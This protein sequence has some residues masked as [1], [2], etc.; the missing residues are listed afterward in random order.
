[1]SL[2]VCFP[3]PPAPNVCYDKKERPSVVTI[4]PPEEADAHGPTDALLAEKLCPHT[5][6]QTPG[7]WTGPSADHKGFFCAPGLRLAI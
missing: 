6:V 1:M 5:S 7:S 2:Y 4:R 3:Q